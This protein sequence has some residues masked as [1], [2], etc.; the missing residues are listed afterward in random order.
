MHEEV[1]QQTVTLVIKGGKIS[2]SLLKAAIAKS[3]KQMDQIKQKTKDKVQ[4]GQ[5]EKK[6]GKTTLRK[7]MNSGAE[8]TNIEVTDKNIKAFEKV[9]RKY[10][11][12][13]GL[14]KDKSKT[15]PVYY[16]FFKAKHVDVMKAAFQEFVG[17]TTL[18]KSQSRQSVIKRLSVARDL[19]MQHRQ[20]Q[21]V[22]G[23]EQQPSL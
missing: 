1:N 5:P 20:R 15:P 16:V 3:L 12:D 18:Q 2:A 8:I 10:D 11:I 7:L 23:K 6:P 13:Y 19:V 9:A 17:K 22:R 14:K 4:K 21:K